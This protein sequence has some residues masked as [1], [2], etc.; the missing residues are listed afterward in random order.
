VNPVLAAFLMQAVSATL[1]V[2]EPAALGKIHPALREVALAADPDER[3]PIY[4]V[5]AE[6]LG[7]QDFFPAVLGMDLAARRAYVVERLRAHAER[8]QAPL[9]RRLELLARE[10]RAEIGERA[11]LG[12]FVQAQVTPSGISAL[13][14][15]PGVETIWW[16]VTPLLEEVRDDGS[17]ARPSAAPP[18]GHAG[19][20]RLL[21]PGNGP[22]ATKADL[23]WAKGFDGSGML[24]GNVDSG[25]R[26][27]HCDLVNR[28]WVNPG[29]IP[30]NGIDDDGNGYVD[31][32]NGWSFATGNNVLT[33]SDGHGTNTAGCIVADGSGTGTIYGQAPG[34]RVI[35]ARVGS[36]SSHWTAVQY[37]LAMGADLQTSS[38][39]YKNNQSPPPNYKMHRDVADLTWAAGLVR[40]NSTSNNGA[41]CTSTTSTVRRPFNISAPGNVPAPYLD[42]AQTLAGGRSGVIGVGAYQVSTGVL[43]TYSPCGPFAWHLADVQAVL[44]SFPLA[45][46][47]PVAHNDYPWS[48]GT[49]MGLRKPDVLAP[50]GTTTSSGNACAT[51]TFS[52]TSNATPVASGVFTLWKSANPSLRPEDIAMIAHQT[53]DDYGLVP[54]KEDTYGAGRLDAL[55]GLRRALCVHRINGDPAWHLQASVAQPYTVTVDT[56]PGATVV[57]VVGFSRG[58]SAPIG[59]VGDLWYVVDI[60]SADANGDL[61]RVFT[62]PPNFAGGTVYTQAATVDTTVF[63]TPASPVLLLSNVVGTTFVP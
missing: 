24:V 33:D 46:W 53:S 3:I 37:V 20:G 45:S 26:V 10:G 13:A 1:A 29:E 54:G 47:D 2:V 49:Q 14:E 15:V 25:I 16:D 12:N 11:W 51:S 32:V 9:L 59:G 57:V 35:T 22:V 4:V 41:S 38:Y 21:P 58:P 40:T 39:S 62:L 31:D 19:A 44:P 61:D 18:G 8:T 36:E 34:A 52:G 60:A 23:V 28:L 63:G 56:L 6:R 27:T 30:G 42:P 7:A 17:G 50:T 55:Q 5:M 48:S 43:A